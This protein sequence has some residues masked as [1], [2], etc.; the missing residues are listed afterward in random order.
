MSN[1]AYVIRKEMRVN[2]I[3][4]SCPSKAQKIRRAIKNF[5]FFPHELP[6]ESLETFLTHNGKEQSDIDPLVQRLNAILKEETDV[7]RVTFSVEAAAMIKSVLQKEGKTGWGI[8][9]AD[10]PAACG[11]GFEYILEPCEKPSPEDIAFSSQGLEIYVPQ[12]CIKRLIGARID[13]EE[14]YTDENFNGFLKLGCTVVNPNIKST[15]DCGCSY[16]YGA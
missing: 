1:A 14:G 11:A 5:A 4:L 8:K 7:N 15:C 2:D 10:H 13:F 9:F 12:A 16:G 3:V 6:Q